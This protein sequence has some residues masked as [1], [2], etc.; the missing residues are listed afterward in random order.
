MIDEQEIKVSKIWRNLNA[1]RLDFEI[2]EDDLIKAILI[3]TSSIF[4]VDKIG[5]FIVEVDAEFRKE[6]SKLIRGYEQSKIY[7][8]STRWIRAEEMLR[9]ILGAEVG[10]PWIKSPAKAI[11]G[12]YSIIMDFS[13]DPSDIRYLFE[14]AFRRYINSI[15]PSDFKISRRVAVLASFLAPENAEISDYF[16][17]SGDL[18][19]SALTK[20][21]YQKNKLHAFFEPPDSLAL[22]LRLGM[23]NMR[24]EVQRDA[25][26]SNSSF[27]FVSH[28]SQM[29]SRQQHLRNFERLTDKSALE[30]LDRLFQKNGGWGL[31]LIVV[32]GA[33]RTAGGFRQQIRDYISKNHLL[34]VVDI[35]FTDSSP[36]KQKTV[37]AWLLSGAVNN[38]DKVL[39]IDSTK[40]LRAT[41]ASNY[42]DALRFVANIIKIWSGKSYGIPDP[43]DLDSLGEFGGMFRQEFRDGYRD[44]AGMCKEISIEELESKNWNLVASKYIF[45]SASRRTKLP[46]LDSNPVLDILKNNN[47]S[48]KRVYVIGNNGEGKSLLLNELIDHL[49]LSGIST[50]GLSFGLTDRFP[51]SKEA[52]E[53]IAQFSYIGAR[54]AEGTVTLRSTNRVLVQYMKR[55]QTEQ[56]RLDVFLSVM[57]VLGFRHSL[58][59]VPLAYKNRSLADQPEIL[60]QVIT[61]TDNAAENLDVLDG[62]SHVSYAIA[63]M[64]KSTRAEIVTFEELSSGEQQL[65][66]LAVKIIA[67]TS[68][69]SV[70]LVD[71]PEISLHVSWQRAI[72]EVFEIISE[73]LQCSIVIATHSPIVIA[74]AVKFE[75]YCF[76]AQRQTLNPITTHKSQSVDTLLFDSFKTYTHQ[77]RRVHELCAGMV[78]K[79]I[80]RINSEGT[81]K[82]TPSDL[83]FDLLVELDCIS[84]VIRSAPTG[85][86]DEQL[87]KDLA[88]VEKA[89]A[90]IGEISKNKLLN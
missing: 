7:Q 73:K 34:A 74:S 57:G 14:T 87:V 3:V 63:L 68:S 46:T 49:S 79:A 88:L 2:A 59:M 72:P 30:G 25:S 10:A 54:T 28:P 29:V 52:T 60:S 24:L 26:L 21:K 47:F 67:N 31:S 13:H 39:F 75:D 44:V 84:E 40:P 35:P 62:N 12:I 5:N 42:E 15:S 90:A 80:K 6:L 82:N 64:R 83:N 32:P 18:V 50:I 65:L 53:E 8:Y 61:L 69:K 43:S 36:S 17:E 22:R 9:E 20:K 71:E 76:V 89:R 66:I 11:S 23:K 58:F 56:K 51:F 55:I 81:D 85:I 45:E 41:G 77:T 1:L 48:S 4:I 33:D 37:S 27:V 70:I 38:R 78:A 16:V 19:F 86:S